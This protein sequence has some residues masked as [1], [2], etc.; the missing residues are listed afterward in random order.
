MKKAVITGEYN[1]CGMGWG[2]YKKKPP[3]KEAFKKKINF[4][5]EWLLAEYPG[6]AE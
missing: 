6:Y 4:E 1:K 2:G 3:V 5:S